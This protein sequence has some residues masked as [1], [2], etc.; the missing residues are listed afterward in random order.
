M[1]TDQFE[2]VADPT[3]PWCARWRIKMAA[4]SWGLTDLADDAELVA[5]EL[6]ANA[7]QAADGRAGAVVRLWLTADDD[8][9]VLSVWDGGD[10]LPARCQAGP[11]DPGGRGLMIVDALSESWGAYESVPGKV[12]WCRLRCKTESLTDSHG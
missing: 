11:L 12:V 9:L 8:S 4:L 1:N 7:V 6:V 5:S 3:A 2:L 10:G